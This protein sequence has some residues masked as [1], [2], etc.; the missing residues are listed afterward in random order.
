[1]DGLTVHKSCHDI[2]VSEYVIHKTLYEWICLHP[3]LKKHTLHIPNE[4]Q[5]SKKTGSCLKK[6]GMRAGASDLFIAIPTKHYHG[7]WI[8]IKKIGGRPTDAQIDFLNDM[9]STG[10][11]TKI[12]YGLDDCISTINGYIK[13]RIQ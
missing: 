5:R 6:L 3:F 8:E 12:C 9:K 1:M 10:Y 2:Y 7:A 4:G 11:Y 13:D